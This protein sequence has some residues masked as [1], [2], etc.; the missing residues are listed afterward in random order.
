MVKIL[1]LIKQGISLFLGLFPKFV[2]IKYP[3]IYQQFLNSDLLSVIQVEFQHS[4]YN[5]L[6]F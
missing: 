6:K 2:I 3:D 1:D 4:S 5:H